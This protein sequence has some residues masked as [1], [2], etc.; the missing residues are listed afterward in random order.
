[1][2]VKILLLS[3][4]IALIAFASCTK[5]TTNTITNTDTITSIVN[6]TDTLKIIDTTTRAV[7]DSTS[8][9]IDGTAFSTNLYPYFQ[10]QSNVPS[11]HLNLFY[12]SSADVA[13]QKYYVGIYTTSNV[14]RAKTYGSFGDSTT[15]AIIEFDSTATNYYFYSSTVL[16]PTTVTITSINGTLIKGTFQGTIYRNGDSTGTGYNKKIVTNGKFTTS[17]L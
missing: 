3:G 16:N 5:T 14:I 4:V 8:A 13:G 1:M 12:F 10:Y 11:N 6:H 7:Y 9:L 15:S 17:L 2:K